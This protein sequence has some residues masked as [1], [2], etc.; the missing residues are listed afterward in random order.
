MPYTIRKV[1]NRRC[2]SV[3]N[4]KTKKV[5]AHCTS[6]EKAQSQVRLLYAIENNKN[7]VL[8]PSKR[9]VPKKPRKTVKKRSPSPK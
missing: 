2:Y 1:R 7:F 9:R 8:D 6:L 5:L 3:K 4:S